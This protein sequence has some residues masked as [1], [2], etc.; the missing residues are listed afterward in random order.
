QL[1]G[2]TAHMIHRL[3]PSI[4]ANIASR[5]RIRLRHDFFAGGYARSNQ[6]TEAAIAF[7]REE[8]DLQLEETYTGKAMAAV[9]QDFGDQQTRRQQFLFW[10]TYNSAALPVDEDAAISGDALPSE[11][12]GYL[13]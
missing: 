11:F 13:S 1:I 6:E 3:D 9:L 12:F 2:K 8:L 5:V 10:N 4:P 7:A